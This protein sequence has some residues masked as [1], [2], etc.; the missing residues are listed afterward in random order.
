MQQKFLFSEI[1]S[2][3]FYSFTP[4][5]TGKK[6]ENAGGTAFET[7]YRIKNS[8]TIKLNNHDKRKI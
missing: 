7:L 2:F 5:M 1:M 3:N 8:K 6:P 4:E